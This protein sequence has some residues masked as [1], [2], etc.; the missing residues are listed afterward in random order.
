MK[1][2]IYLLLLIIFTQSCGNTSKAYLDEISKKYDPANLELNQGFNNYISR[3]HTPEGIEVGYILFSDGD[4]A[5][6]WFR[7]HHHSNDKGCTLFELSN[8]ERLYMDGLFC[9]E[10]QLPE[11]QLKNNFELKGFI[12][13]YNGISP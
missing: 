11:N 7:S 5:K 2:Y 3:T 10:V 12:K 1:I 6:F 4:K 13:K 8:G 9:C